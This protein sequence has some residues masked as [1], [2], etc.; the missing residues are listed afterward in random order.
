MSQDFKP[1]ESGKCYACIQ[2]EGVRSYYPE[3]KIFKVDV[4]R[5]GRCLVLQKNV[6]GESTCE[7]YFPLR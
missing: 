7:H 2:W 4:K 1:A 3:K 6:K 5:E